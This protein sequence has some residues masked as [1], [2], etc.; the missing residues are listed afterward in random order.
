VF[1]DERRVVFP[2]VVCRR[3][4]SRPINTLFVVDTAAP[5]TYLREETIIALGFEPPTDAYQLVPCRVG[6]VVFSARTSRSHFKNVDLLGMDWIA[7]ARAVLTVN[8]FAKSAEMA[9]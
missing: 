3:D 7:Q 5:F 8:P 6:H 2:L 1:G 9:V 4:G